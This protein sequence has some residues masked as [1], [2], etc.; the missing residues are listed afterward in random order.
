MLPRVAAAVA[1]ATAA[2]AAVAVFTAAAGGDSTAAAA[3]VSMAVRVPFTAA[4]S[5]RVAHPPADLVQ[6]GL[7]PCPAEQAL[8]EC[9]V[10]ASTTTS[11]TITSGTSSRLG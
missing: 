9:P 7:L 3:A 4:A 10:G 5:P 1:A 8:P 6:P 2:A 11:I